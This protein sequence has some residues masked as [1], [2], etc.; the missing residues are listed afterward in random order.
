MDL[1]V[2]LSAVFGWFILNLVGISSPPSWASGVVGCCQ[3]HE[4]LSLK[5]TRVSTAEAK[6][7]GSFLASNVFFIVFHFAF[8]LDEVS[9]AVQHVHDLFWFVLNVFTEVVARIPGVCRGGHNEEQSHE[10]AAR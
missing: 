5:G 8:H 3:S 4:V 9:E 6:I 7:K 10:H 2:H 1:L